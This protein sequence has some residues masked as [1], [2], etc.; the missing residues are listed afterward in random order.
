MKKSKKLIVSLAAVA[1]A[2]VPVITTSLNQAHAA[3]I[4]DQ[5]QNKIATDGTLTLNHNTRIYNKKGQKLYS[6]QRSNGLLKK[7]ATVSY[8]DKPQTIADPDTV[9]YSFH[10]DDWNW[11]YLP[12]KTIKGQ[13]YYSIGHGGYVKAANVEKINGNDLYTNQATGTIKALKYSRKPGQ[14]VILDSN[15]KQTKSYMKVGQKVTLDR[16]SNY[17]DLDNSD[18]DNNGG[19]TELYGVKDQKDQYLW[20]NAININCRQALL[21]YSNYMHVYVTNDT[22]I[23]NNS[24]EQYIPKTNSNEIILGNKNVSVIP[25]KEPQILLKGTIES[26]IKETYIK[27]PNESKPELFYQLQSSND[28]VDKFIKASDTKYMYGKQL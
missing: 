10:D 14:E 7:G 18:P 19:T 4:T 12:Y 20:S 24:G 9:R 15:G 28:S 11:F 13:E 2:T 25:S 16:Q 22:N 26:V 17:H 21:P 5:T 23:Y 27:L 8:V 3:Q 1:L 6:Y